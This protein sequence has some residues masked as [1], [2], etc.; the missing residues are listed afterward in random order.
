[1]FIRRSFQTLRGT[2]IFMISFGLLMVI[3]IVLGHMPTLYWLL[4]PLPLVA[5]QLMGFGLGLACGTLCVFF[6]DLAQ[7]IPLVLRLAMWLA[8]VL[9]P[10]AN[11]PSEKLRWLIGLHPVS[12]NLDAIQARLA[13]L[14]TVSHLEHLR[15]TGR[16]QDMKREGKIVYRA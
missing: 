16:I 1:M 7:L 14:E 5:L 10:L 13:F 12:P 8:P 15:L 3:S 2:F 9:Y 4:L 6:R 11:I